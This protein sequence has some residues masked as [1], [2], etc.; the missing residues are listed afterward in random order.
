MMLRMRPS[1]VLFGDSITQQGFS[2]GGKSP[3]WAGL[4]ANEYTRRADVL[5]RGFSGYTSRMALQLLPSVFGPDKGDAATRVGQPL[6]VTVLLGSNDASLPS[7]MEHCQHVPIDEYEANIKEIV[8]SIGGRFQGDK[9]PILLVTPPPVSQ[10]MWNNFCM[11]NFG[12]LAPRTNGVTK[13]YGDRVKSVAKE[14][15]CSVVDAFSR[16]GGNEGEETYGK[17]LDDGLHLNGSGNKLLFEAVKDVLR[18]DFPQLLPMD[19][20]G[21]SGESGIPLE[22]PLWKDLC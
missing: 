1:I 21:K 3:G 22:A 6:F 4:L 9:P 12:E 13:Q 8:A 7:E 14:L 2:Y 19:G 17:N 10:T 20:D 11:E 15:G 16:L 18:S 5:N